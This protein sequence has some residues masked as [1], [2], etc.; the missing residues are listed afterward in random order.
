DAEPA[1]LLH[2][3]DVLHDCRAERLGFLGGGGDIV[4]A[5]IGK[6][7]R[8][9]TGDH[10]L[11]HSAPSPLSDVDQRIGAALGRNVLELPIKQLAVKI[12]GLDDVA[13]IELHVDKWICHLLLLSMRKRNRHPSSRAALAEGELAATFV[14]Y[15]TGVASGFPFSTMYVTSALAD[16]LPVFLAACTVPAGTKKASPAFRVARGLPS[17]S[18]STVPS[19]P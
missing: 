9:R 3:G 13:R 2:L 12:L 11:H 18:S 1:K 5:H 15:F 6:P 10:L 8:G 19:Q 14:G 4:H 17:N 7:G 16:V